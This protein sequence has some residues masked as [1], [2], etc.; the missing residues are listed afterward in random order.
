MSRKYHKRVAGET[1]RQRYDKHR[2]GSCTIVRYVDGV[3]DDTYTIPAENL[4][5]DKFLEFPEKVRPTTGTGAR[6]P[7]WSGK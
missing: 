7:R 4:R 2:H 3:P 6:Y 5:R 1:A